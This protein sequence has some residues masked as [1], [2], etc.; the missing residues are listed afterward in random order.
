LG[1]MLEPHVGLQCAWRGV[2]AC[3]DIEHEREHRKHILILYIS[4]YRFSLR[5]LFSSYL[6]RISSAIHSFRHVH[7]CMSKGGKSLHHY[8]KSTK[9]RG[10]LSGASEILEFG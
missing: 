4:M 2:V 1:G 3:S 8:H 9:P 10:I 5:L 7:R 6:W